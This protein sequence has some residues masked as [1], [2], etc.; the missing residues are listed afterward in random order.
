MYILTRPCQKVLIRCLVIKNG[1]CCEHRPTGTPEMAELVDKIENVMR[2]VN[3]FGFTSLG[4]GDYYY[5]AN[6]M[7]RLLPTHKGTILEL[8]MDSFDIYYDHHPKWSELESAIAELFSK[9]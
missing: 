9:Q 2:T 1:F 4:G 7:V 8:C 6:N 3:P 5:E